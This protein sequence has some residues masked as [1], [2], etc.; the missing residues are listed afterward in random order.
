[1]AQGEFLWC[2]LATF[3]VVDV[4]PDY[5]DL[6]G[7]SFRSEEFADGSVYYFA[8]NRTDVTAGIYEMP[9]VYR[10]DGMH[11]FWMT[12]VG[13]AD[14]VEGID[15]AVAEGGRVLLGPASFG[16][17]ASIAMIADPD[18]AIL[19]LFSGSHLQHRPQKMSHGSHFWNELITRDMER[20]RDFY[21][22]LFGWKFEPGEAEHRLNIRNMAGSPT[23]SMRQMPDDSPADMTPHWAVSFAVGDI[24]DVQEASKKLG[25]QTR[26]EPGMDGTVRL[27]L[28]DRHGAS[29]YAM[30]VDA[31]KNSWFS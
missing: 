19:T 14:I 6:F 4:L 15:I 13:I 31:R 24:M 29:F 11:S 27:M 18:G 23:A 25:L 26:L 17:G 9:Q 21:G 3:D 20:S 1:M 30:P 5:A 2:D 10:D 22:K 12:Y 7:W 28:T 16:M 8:S